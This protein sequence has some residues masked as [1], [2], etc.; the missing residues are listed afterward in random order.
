MLAFGKKKQVNKQYSPWEGVKNKAPE[1]VARND[2]SCSVCSLLY[3][4]LTF[5]Y[6]RDLKK[7]NLDHQQLWVHEIL[8]FFFNPDSC[9]MLVISSPLRDRDGGT[10]YNLLTNTEKEI[11][12]P[13]N[14]Y[15]LSFGTYLRYALY[16]WF[17]LFL[18]RSLLL[19]SVSDLRFMQ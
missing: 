19:C 3:E 6:N 17:Y 15:S 10:M 9:T 7:L 16:Q 2:F 11:Y 14:S 8:T 1:P 18:Q 4:A 12:R 13:F 5:K